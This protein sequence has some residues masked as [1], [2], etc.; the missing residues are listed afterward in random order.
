MQD[1]IFSTQENLSSYAPHTPS[2]LSFFFVMSAPWT[3][4][5]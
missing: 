3:S 5:N 2:P 1:K 4:T